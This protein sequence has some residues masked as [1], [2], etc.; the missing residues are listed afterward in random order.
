MS[1]CSTAE[2]K[3]PGSVTGA[4]PS[5]ADDLLDGVPAIA[6]YL[7]LS[8]RRTYYLLESGQLPAFKI[9][10][11]WA[12]RKSTYLSHFDKLERGVVA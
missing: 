10:S 5:L 2:S 3:V 8:E 11:K 9:G 6:A 12:G 1:Q 7:G 4:A